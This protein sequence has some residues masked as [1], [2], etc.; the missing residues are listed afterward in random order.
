MPND[1]LAKKLT[2]S[3][4]V[5]PPT[6]AELRQAVED[7]VQK[8]EEKPAFDPNDPMLR[9]EYVFPFTFTSGGEKFEGTFTSRVL[10]IATRQK[11]GVLRAM[12]A[13]GVAFEVLD[14]NTR[15]ANFLRATLAHALV[16]TKEHPLPAWAK[17]L[18]ALIDIDIL[19]ALY[20]VVQ[21]HEA[22]FL[23]RG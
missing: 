6:D 3:H 12:L 10:D 22:T 4:L 16:E 2:P 20:E 1:D 18:G 17:N 11:V 7:A 21:K 14:P 8:G 15:D 9:R 5:P 19:H 13:G 23:R